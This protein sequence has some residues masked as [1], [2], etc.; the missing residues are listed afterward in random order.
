M[1]RTWS[2]NSAGRFPASMA[3]GWCGARSC[4]RCTGRR[5]TRRSAS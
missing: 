5:F 1:C 2:S 4:A 3:T